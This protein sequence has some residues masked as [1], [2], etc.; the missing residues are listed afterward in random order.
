MEIPDAETCFYNSIKGD[1]GS[2]V[3]RN[4]EIAELIPVIQDVVSDGGCF[5]M[6]GGGWSMLPFIRDQDEIIVTS[7]KNRNIR[8]GDI[9][10]YIRDDGTYVIHRVFAKKAEEIYS[11]VGDNQRDIE[12]GIHKSQILFYV[13]EVVRNGKVYNCEK[14]II[15]WIMTFYMFIRIR[16]PFVA[17]RFLLP[18]LNQILHNREMTQ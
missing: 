17:Y 2:M 10:F 11:F 5:R 14:G 6:R 7:L 12:K 16:Y 13:K 18:C 9:L 4:I 15:R 1:S 8:V 3:Q